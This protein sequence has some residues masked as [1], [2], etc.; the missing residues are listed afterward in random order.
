[1]LDSRHVIPL[2]FHHDFASRS[3]LL[4]A[5]CLTLCHA[6]SLPA[7]PWFE[8]ASQV[9]AAQAVPADRS[10]AAR[11]LNEEVDG[12]KPLDRAP[13]SVPPGVFQVLPGFQVELLY[14]VPKETQGSWVSLTKDPQGRLL[15][16]DQ[17][18]AGI[19]RITPSPMGSNQPTRV[20]KLDLGISS[21]Q[22]MLCAFDSL[23]LSI[24]GGPGS[25][26]YRA[27]DTNGD[28][29][30][31]E[32]I[33]LKELAGGGEHGPHSLR[34]APDGKSL[35]LVA[36][37]HTD[38]PTGL[39]A[40]RLPTNWAEDLLLP[41]QWDARGHARGRLAPG[42]WIAKVDPDGKEWQF[43]SSGY[44][45]TFDIA[46]NADGELFAYD[47]DME[48]DFGTPWYRPTRL[49]H[50]TSGSEFGW[51]SG[52][53]KW[54]TYYPD[55]LPAVVDIGPGSPVGVAF[56]YGTR[57]PGRYQRAIYVLDWTFGTMY[58]IHLEPE[59]ASYRGTKEEFVAR[60]P[61]PLTD[62]VVG[63]DGALYFTVGGR[64]T[65]SEL[66]R[67]TYIGP[68]AIKPVELTDRRNADLR[69]LRNQLEQ[70]HRPGA[71]PTAIAEALE[72]LGHAD[73]HIRYAARLVLENQPI[74][75]W[76]DEVLHL[77]QPLAAIEGAIA[78]ARQGDQEH[79]APVLS[80]LGRVDWPSLPT[81]QQLAILR[82]YAL[83]FIR[84]GQP[85]PAVKQ[86]LCDRFESH[87][88]HADPLVNRELVQ[89]LV[90]LESPQVIEKTLK[91][92]ARA[93]D[94][95]NDATAIP[96]LLTRNAG[97]GETI[98]EML[99]NRPQLQNLHY[100][101][102][103]RNVRY[104]WT[105]EQRVNYLKWL[106]EARSWSGGA[107]Y[108]GFIDNIR[109]EAL[110][111]A[112]EAELAMLESD[113][114]A[115]RPVAKADLPQPH[116]PGHD[117]TMDDLVTLTQHGIAGRDYARG[118]RA[119]A[120]ARCVVCHR[121]AG[122]GGATGPDLTNVAG[123]FSYRDLAEAIVV[124]SKVVSDQYRAMN[125][126]TSSGRVVT[127][128]VVDGTG[129]TV[130]V[131]TDPE[132]PSKIVKIEKSD[133]EQIEPATVSLMPNDLL[134][135]LNRDEVLDLLA[136]LMSRANPSA[137]VFATNE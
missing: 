82:A 6:V 94:L 3:T 21:A 132:D 68:D 58:A 130:E 38:P 124:P 84:L 137:P 39:Q 77:D 52:T 42:G 12:A 20:E 8:Q 98:A 90:F 80:R 134:K 108:E 95:D 109:K 122:K 79:L 125:V 110:A 1:M 81:E 31:D 47:A 34:V 70:Y 33:K 119:F 18:D 74:S 55:S 32:L 121:F 53:G 40:S 75:A 5:F 22:G 49:L 115:T 23:Y 19:Y 104:G 127:G 35:L 83:A 28:D 13:V 14:T 96:E 128:R 17:E 62:A 101:F 73:R 88:P 103:L 99:V 102:V 29:Q 67:V 37:N 4:F 26:L 135:P 105:L 56:G 78:L 85:S 63:D 50:A 64:G 65:Q 41:R 72:Q 126:V 114:L 36:G 118:E 133:V 51:R 92:M 15:A 87:Y 25:G 27:R 117:W 107:S 69:Q 100:A 2:P 111:N 91:E 30:Y 16:S 9:V 123:R 24:N 136:Y 54:P 93:P 89:I 66:F 86:S 116:G 48:W 45:N 97:Y 43:V 44:R 10:D 71:P 7:D 106:D 76:T 57:F 112:S 11:P 131:L 120:A 46:L 129:E 61:L 60:T 113:Q 59:G